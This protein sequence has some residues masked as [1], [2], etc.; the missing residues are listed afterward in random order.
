MTIMVQAPF[1][2]P[3]R[4]IAA[5][6]SSIESRMLKI[7]SRKLTGMDFGLREWILLFGGDLPFS[8]S[9]NEVATMVIIGF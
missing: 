3:E 9:K 4:Q 7:H 8:C 2:E 5:K 1:F 6:S